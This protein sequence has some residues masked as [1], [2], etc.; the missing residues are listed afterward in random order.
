MFIALGALLGLMLSGY[1]TWRFQEQ[2][3]EMNG[4]ITAE[5][6]LH[7]L[8][9]HDPLTHLPNRLQFETVL[10]QATLDARPDPLAMHCCCSI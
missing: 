10:A 2:R 7:E 5:R 4:H 1:A 3:R 6:A 8:T 9:F